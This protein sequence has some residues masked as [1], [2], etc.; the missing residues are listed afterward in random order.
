MSSLNTQTP[1]QPP[2]NES[3]R[4]ID[5]ALSALQ[6]DYLIIGRNHIRGW[7]VWLM[8]GLF[9]GV[10]TGVV[11]VANKGGEVTPSAAQVSQNRVV[12][13]ITPPVETSK[14]DVL[15]SFTQPPGR[16]ENTLVRNYR[17]S[18]KYSYHLVSAVAAQIPET[19][20]AKLLRHP[21]VTRIELDGTVHA[22]DAELDN[23]WGVQRT[24]AG[25][26][27]G[28]G[29]TGVGVAVAILDSG[30]D[31][32]HPDVGPNIAG[33]FDFVN[34]DPDPMDDNGHGTHVA[35]TVAALDNDIGVVGVAPEASLY[36][37]KVL[38]A[39][40]SGSW[41]DII[42]ALEWAVD[43]GIQVTNNSY[44]SG[45]N[46]GGIVQAAF[47]NSAAAG[48]LH[49]AAAGNSGN[50]RGKGNNVGWP[51]RYDSVV[52]VAATDQNDNRAR[53]S[54]TGDQVELAAPGVDINSTKLGG[55]YIEFDGTSMAS[56]H[57]A[58]AAALVIA[59]GIT[60]TSGNGLINDEVRQALN[61]TATDLGDTGRDSLYGFGLVNV[62][63]A[64]ATVAPP[65]TGTIS[66][67]VTDVD[68]LDPIAG[69]TVTDGIRSVI[70]DGIGVYALADVPE[71]TY[72]VT[73]SADDYTS[74]SQTNVV[75][76]ADV[77]TTVDLAL[78]VI[79][80]GAIEGTVTDVDTGNPIEGAAVTDGTR[81]ATTDATGYYSMT[82]VPEGTYTVVA[83]AT[84]YEDASWEA[85]VTGGATSTANFSL[86]AVTQATSVI[87]DSVTY[88]TEGG[89]NQDKHLLITVAL[90]DDLGSVVSGAS[91]SIDLYRD[92]TRIGSGAGTT[93]VD[94]TATFRLKNARAGCYKTEATN[95]SAAGLTWDG[96]TPT[97][98]FCK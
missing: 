52:A 11:L 20:V 64:V 81:Q 78:T 21:S 65:A 70:T 4:L 59:A 36:A 74:A 68:T 89:K 23:T 32:T 42:A 45:K 88:A 28:I 73:A 7:H 87:V 37:L 50:P 8:L 51:A 12:F 75:V 82:D 94:G 29:N 92:G 53:F 55:G 56:P 39:S 63:A 98:E 10:V 96:L 2:Q 91:V 80:Y 18:I 17:G 14:I 54:S 41:S 61:N 38:N 90:V 46:P 83:S 71:G 30:I 26:V 57:V 79:V 47:D 58:G 77:T 40:G 16:N 97:N 49:I 76:T 34:N 15:I 84:G 33:G 69:A 25:T 3:S 48:I 67:T 13:P 6:R 95:V 9:A 85:A 19:A 22:L 5:R 1:D 93:G 66:G 62:A 24:G 86:Q 35:G 60:D 44:G 31:A 27:H 72:T 43:N